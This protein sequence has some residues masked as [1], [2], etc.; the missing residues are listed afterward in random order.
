[1]DEWDNLNGTIER[2]YGGAS[3]F[4]DAG[5]ARADMTRVGE[6]GRMLASIGINGCAISNVNADPKILSPDF[7][8]QIAK[9]ADALRPWGVHVALAVSFDSPKKIGGLDTFDPLDPKVTDWW[10]TTTDGIYKSDTGYREWLRPWKADS[11]GRLGPLGLWP[12]RHADAANVV[13]RALAP[14]NGLFFYQRLRVRQPHG[15]EQS[16]KRPRPRRVGQLPRARRA[17]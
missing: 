3:I 4:W 13:A 8:P 6:Y 9:I 11:E 10:K 2:G 14:H 7:I 15:L 1:M 12:Q 17:V 5:N 16:E